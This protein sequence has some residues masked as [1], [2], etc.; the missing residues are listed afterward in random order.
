MKI[1]VTNKISIVF[2]CTISIALLAGCATDKEIY[3]DKNISIER[4][5]SIMASI[6]HADLYKTK[7][8]KIVLHGELKKKGYHRGQIPGHLDIELINLEGKIF[9]KAQINYNL[10]GSKFGVSLFS[11]VIPVDPASLS[12]VRVIH[13]NAGSHKLNVKISPWQDVN[14]H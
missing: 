5:D 3:R 11:I 8:S 13:H 2:L 7:E 1:K 6:T 12:S 9:N 10:R 4:I 14:P